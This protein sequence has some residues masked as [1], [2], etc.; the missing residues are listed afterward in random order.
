MFP[1]TTPD[2]FVNCW[3]DCSPQAPSFRTG[4][5]TVS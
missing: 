2:D 3:S 1:E 4:S 5:L